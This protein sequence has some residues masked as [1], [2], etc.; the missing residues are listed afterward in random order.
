MLYIIFLGSSAVAYTVITPDVQVW[1]GD[2]MYYKK[3]NDEDDDD[4]SFE[5]DGGDD[6]GE[7]YDVGNEIYEKNIIYEDD[8]AVEN[9]S[10]GQ[11]QRVWVKCFRCPRIFGSRDDWVYHMK[12]ECCV[13]ILKCFKCP[14]ETTTAEELEVHHQLEHSTTGQ[15]SKSKSSNASSAD[16]DPGRLPC[17]TCRR[18]YKYSRHLKYHL[19]YECGKQPRFACS[20]CSYRCNQ[21]NKMKQHEERIHNHFTVGPVKDENLLKNEKL[22]EM[23]TAQN[24]TGPINRK[25]TGIKYD[26]SL[27][28]FPAEDGRFHCEN[29]PK[30]FKRLKHLQY[31]V[32]NECDATAE[33]LTCQN[34]GFSTKV[35][36]SFKK[37]VDSCPGGQGPSYDN[38]AYI[39][40]TDK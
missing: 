24:S 38:H 4:G 27:K 37:H 7:S 28:F 17:P 29:C 1:E 8:S 16:D 19:K 3:E 31:H 20:Y 30:H 6:G 5:E 12:N 14:Y 2:E 32:K 13:A 40:H 39:G 22:A 21:R 15:K 9:Y 11:T 10:V 34:C 35:R 18:T 25:R 23:K 36:Y 33:P 26:T